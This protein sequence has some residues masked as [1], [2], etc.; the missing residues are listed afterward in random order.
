MR[1]Q[2]SVRMTAMEN[3]GWLQW[4]HS[5]QS[6]INSSGR[7]PQFTGQSLIGEKI[8]FMGGDSIDHIQANQLFK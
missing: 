3:L 1:L 2:F 5:T 7:N 6:P 4:A 8:I